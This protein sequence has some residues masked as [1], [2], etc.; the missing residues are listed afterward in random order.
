MGGICRFKILGSSGLAFR[1]PG[2]GDWKLG[3]T[4]CGWGLCRAE[5]LLEELSRRQG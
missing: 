3:S 2:F 1:V 5:G 4:V